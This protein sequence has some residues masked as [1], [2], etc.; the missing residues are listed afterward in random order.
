[1]T[2][3]ERPF[4]IPGHWHWST[5]QEIGEWSGGGTPSKSNESYWNGTIPWV[6]PKD[7]KRLE[8]RDSQDHVTEK[9]VE[10][11]STKLIPSESILFVTR[12]GILERTLPTAITTVDTTI[13][14]DLKALSVSGKINSQFILYYTRAAERSILRHCAKDGTTV[15]SL[16][17]SRLYDF[18]VPI[19]PLQEQ[20]RIV[21]RIE[22][23][24]S[25]LDAGM[26]SLKRAE[27][28]LERYRVSVLQAAV[29]GRLTA[30]WRKTHNPEPADE[31]VQWAI[32]QDEVNKY[33]SRGKMAPLPERYPFQLPDKWQWVRVGDLARRI[34]YGSSEKAERAYKGI[35]VLRM[36]NIEEGRLKYDDLKFM[37]R[38]WN[39]QEKF[40][41]QDGDVLFNRT[42]SAELVG[43]TAVYK[44]S[45]P[46]AGFASYLVRVRLYQD[47][48]EPDLL[49]Y[50]INSIH[51]RV[52]IRQVTSQQVGQ[53]NVNAT[54]LA[55][56]PVPLP[57]IVEQKQIIEKVER[58]LSIADDA[59]AT[60]DSETKRASRL[61]Q[62]ILRDAF[63]GKLTPKSKPLPEVERATL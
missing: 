45:H 1:M 44:E 13:N 22:E 38:D 41:L 61:R 21:S 2:G 48:Y 42:N 6:S 26:K 54:K 40:L 8:I 53:A 18:P 43:K 30:E 63:S 10:E 62:S 34:R 35:P 39:D 47:I 15:A 57:P 19:P 3:P 33:K 20:R 7:M 52:Y 29:E 9:A 16:E 56:M 28:Q 25:N 36:G 5:F 59:A 24:F 55:S 51:G 46:R 31:L 27:R 17:S 49:A 11:S 58:L 4:E 14:Q 60:S 23:L 37:P 12:S 50:Y 32:E